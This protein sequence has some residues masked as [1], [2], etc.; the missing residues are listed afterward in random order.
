MSRVLLIPEIESSAAQKSSIITLPHPATSQPTR[1]LFTQPQCHL[2]ELTSVTSDDPCS[3]ILSTS[4]DDDSE[5][6]RGSIISSGEIIVATAV[7]PL[8]LLLPAL[9]KHAQQYRTWEDLSD[10]L[11]SSAAGFTVLLP[12][13]ERYLA[14]ITDTTEPAP[15]MVCY[16]L[17][18]D[19]LFT[20][21]DGLATEM[22]SRLPTAVARNEVGRVLQRARA[23]DERAPEE[24]YARARKGVAVR[25]LCARFVCAELAR[26]FEARVADDGELAGYISRLKKEREEEMERHQ[27]LSSSVG[28]K[29]TRFEAE[30]DE[31][32]KGKGTKAKKAA[33]GAGVRR[34]M[35]ADRSGMSR[36]DTFFKKK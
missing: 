18:K 23:S 29:R 16:R 32:R 6:T 25:V 8:F 19:K 13:L 34:L 31:V 12:T 35:K 7:S 10:T 5:Q 1:F 14:G 11:V 21:L 26:E 9:A 3:T 15:G 4:D 2:S 30:D 36:L 33:V 27:M 17:N 28:G 20:K 24:M 22:G